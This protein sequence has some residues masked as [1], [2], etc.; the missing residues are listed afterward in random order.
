MDVNG[1]QSTMDRRV[2]SVAD[3][4][5]LVHGFTMADVHNVARLAVHVSGMLVGTWHERYDIAWSAVVEHLFSAEA[6]PERYDLVRAGRLALYE[7]INDEYRH[8]GYYKAKTYGGTHGMGSSPAFSKYWWDQLTVIPPADGKIVE[9]NA[10]MQI[11]AALSATDRQALTA[12]AVYDGDYRAAAEALG[13]TYQGFRRAISRARGRAQALWFDDETPH[14]GSFYA[15][16]HHRGQQADP[17]CGTI[18]A[19]W[20]HRR[21]KER[22]CE[23]CAPVEAAYQSDRRDRARDG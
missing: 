2:G 8:Y 1:N 4:M 7:V 15:V 16:R 17:V 3:S 22:L 18:N 11:W 21:R 9:R 13:L 19:V 5:D 14:R 23:E 10:L 6:P 20:S 12:C